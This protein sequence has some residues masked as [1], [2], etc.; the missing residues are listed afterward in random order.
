M[1]KALRT[2]PGPQ[3]LLRGLTGLWWQPLQCR[4]LGDCSSFRHKTCPTE[5]EASV[6]RLIEAC[7]RWRASPRRL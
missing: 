4:Q 5:L 1:S 6:V 7:F 3:R 2:H